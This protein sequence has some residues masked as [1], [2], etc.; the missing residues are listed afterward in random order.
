[1]DAVR[2]KNVT[3][4]VKNIRSDVV[5]EKTPW[6]AKIMFRTRIRSHGEESTEKTIYG[7]SF[8]KSTHL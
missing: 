1:L 6:S 3:N 4:K 5:K 2:Y 8:R 7:A